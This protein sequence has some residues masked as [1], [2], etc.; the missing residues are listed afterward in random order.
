MGIDK[1]PV[2]FVVH[3]DLPQSTSEWYQESGRAGR[4]NKYSFCR[5]YYDRD[6]VKSISFLLNREISF[7]KDKNSDQLE[8]AKQAFK[9]FQKISDHCESTNCR[10]KFFTNFFGDAPPNC[11][12]MCDACKNK[13]K[14]KKDLEKFQMVTARASLGG[15]NQ[16]P[17]VDPVNLYEGGRQGKTGSFEDYENDS[18]ESSG[19]RKASDILDKRAEKS[20]IEK[21][22]ALRKAQA[23]EAIEMMPT[24]QISRVRAAQSTGSRIGLTLPVRETSLTHLTDTLKANM[25][26]CEKANPPETPLHKLVYK[27]LEDIAKEIEYGCFSNCKAISVYRMKISKALVEIKGKVGLHPSIQNHVPA[28]RQAFGG[29]YKTVV[30]LAKERYGDD[31]VK[32]LEDEK[33]K[34]IERV[35][36]DKFKQSGRDGLNQTRINS[37]FSK[38][39]NRSPDASSDDDVVTIEMKDEPVVIAGSSSEGSDSEEMVKLK[40]I[41]QVL[42]KELEKTAEEVEEVEKEAF[43]PE[44]FKIAAAEEEVDDKDVDSDDRLVIAESP[45]DKADCFP[46]APP[47]KRKM[48][49]IPLSNGSVKGSV[50]QHQSKKPRIDPPAKIPG[51]PKIHLKETIAKLVLAELNPFYKEKKFESDD[52]KS[53]FK[54]MARELTHHFFESS[55]KKVPSK[56]DIHI[57]VNEIFYNKGIIRCTD[58]FKTNIAT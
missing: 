57:Y 15:F 49:S 26:K 53:L 45:I 25:E 54:S 6:E 38:N 29:D 21:Q 4:D 42:Q 34:K 37:F 14:A 2:R 58:D 47:V 51:E 20:F 39:P 23:A 55:K 56:S 7:S 13:T 8:I 1:G 10:H 41:K 33:T 32:E 46:T 31:V 17:D 9:E 12:E 30:S 11:K 36:K 5:C 3:W 35:K 27:D 24:S 50:L 40:L 22:F 48:H 52:P 16:M 19:F 28:K 18:G 44:V 43:N